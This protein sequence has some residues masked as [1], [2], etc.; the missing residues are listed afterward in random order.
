M[1]LSRSGDSEGPAFHP[2][3]GTKEVPIIE[4]VVNQTIGSVPLSAINFRED[5]F[6]IADRDG[7]VNIFSRP[8]PM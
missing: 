5:G 7:T 8:K 6:L 4:P 3:P 2:C 1:E